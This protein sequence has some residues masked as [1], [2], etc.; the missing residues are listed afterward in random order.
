M[1]RILIGDQSEILVGRGRPDPLLP[2]RPVRRRAAVFAQPGTA[3]L[4]EEIAHRLHDEGVET[5]THMMPD[6]EE[7][8]TLAAVEAAYRRLADLGL[9]RDDTVVAV[10]GGALTDAAGFVAGTWMRGI[11]SVYLPTTLLGAVDAAIGGKTGVNIGGKN[12]VGVFWHPRRVVVDLDVL[13]RLPEEL[14]RQ[15]AAEI[16]K[17]GLLADPPVVDAY[18]RE[19][20]GVVL[21]EVVPAAIRVKTDIV[22]GDFTERGQRGL[23]NL[24]HTI[25]HGIEF[26]AGLSHG[27]SVAIGLVAAA[28]VSQ[29]VLGFE[30]TSEVT[31]ALE[32]VG[33]P[34]Q[35][36][37]LDR[38]EVIRLVGLDKKRSAGQLRMVLLEAPGRPRLMEVSAD[39]LAWGLDAVGA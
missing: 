36:P 34:V 3:A 1:E 11:E 39:D 18:R 20:L 19:G 27:D 25:G 12:L 13:E 31:S 14:K 30:A 35:A 10:G 21:D 17:A 32:A 38:D 5:G 33:L 6:R 15:G 29:R 16:I 24:G 23:L 9:G 8:K 22:A 26:A 7:A 2:A 4:A 37:P 28:A